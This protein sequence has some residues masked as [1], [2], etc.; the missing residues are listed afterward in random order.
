MSIVMWNIRYFKSI[1]H[2]TIP[3]LYSKK[4]RKKEKKKKKKKINDKN[5]NWFQN[6]EEKNETSLYSTCILHVGL[7]VKVTCNF[8]I[9]E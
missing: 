3:L 6:K 4:N 9:P 2:G 8:Y 7:F 5:K 1:Q